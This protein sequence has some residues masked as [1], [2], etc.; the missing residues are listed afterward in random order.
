MEDDV[1]KWVTFYFSNWGQSVSVVGNNSEWRLMT[2][3][4]P[5]GPVAGPFC[6]PQNHAP[7]FETVQKYG[8]EFHMY[9]D[10]TLIYL[11]FREGNSLNCLLKL[12]NYINEIINLDK[13]KL[14]L[15]LND[16]KTEL[17]VINK[18]TCKKSIMQDK[19]TFQLQ[20]VSVEVVL[21]CS[22]FQKERCY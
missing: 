20:K 14:F 21:R 2:A 19:I 9:A 16:S 10:D 12:E 22:I 18:I 15:K 6:F 1:Q 3:G 11:T 8:Y 5:Q 17:L 7:F 4:I 13:N